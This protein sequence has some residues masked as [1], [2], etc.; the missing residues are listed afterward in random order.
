MMRNYE[1]FAAQLR[2]EI[3]DAG[4]GRAEPDWERLERP[5]RARA[6]AWRPAWAA[7]VLAVIVGASGYAT[8][9]SYDGRRLIAEQNT[10]FVEAL[11][12]RGLFDVAAVPGAPTGTLADEPLYP[13]PDAPTVN[14]GLPWASD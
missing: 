9:R 6:G 1:E 7:A 10:A 13:W 3:R 11:L 12:A 5:R 8:W 2:R 4:P 14:A